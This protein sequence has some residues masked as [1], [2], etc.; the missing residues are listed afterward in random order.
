MSTG[1]IPRFSRQ[2]RLGERQNY[3][4]L[5]VGSLS[6]E[7]LRSRKGMLGEVWEMDG[8]SMGAAMMYYKLFLGKECKEL[9]R[10]LRL[11]TK[12]EQVEG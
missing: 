6:V 12:S 1:L 8:E 3:L 5:S 11:S 4:P 10:V 9:R 2:A 7:N